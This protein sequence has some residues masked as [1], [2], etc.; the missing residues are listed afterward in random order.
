VQAICE[1]GHRPRFD[2]QAAT[3]T[4][5]ADKLLDAKKRSLEKRERRLAAQ[6]RRLG[7][8]STSFPGQR[9]WPVCLTDGNVKNHGDRGNQKSQPSSDAGHSD[10]YSHTQC[11]RGGRCDVGDR[12]A[13][14]FDQAEAA[15]A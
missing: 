4:V 1:L 11:W 15:P 12:L 9:L 10:N 6:T 13:N 2:D 14:R 8:V 3:R 7:A 5:L